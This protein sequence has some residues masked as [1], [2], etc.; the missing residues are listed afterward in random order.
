MTFFLSLTSWNLMVPTSGAFIG[1]ENYGRMIS[2]RYFGNAILITLILI[3]GPVAFQMLLGLALALLLHT[4]LPFLPVSRAVFI[5]PMV[6]P[7]VIAGLIWKVL[8]IPNLG[9]VNYFLGLVG[10]SGPNWLDTPIWA[11]IA[12]GLVAIWEDTPFVMLLLLAALDSLPPEPFEAAIVDGASVWQRIRFV[13]IPLITPA[14]LVAVLFRIIASLNIF[15]VIYVM[16]KGGPGRFTEVLNYYAY[17]HGFQFLDIG[18]A[19]ALAM[20]LFVLIV[21]LSGLF[22]VLRVR[23]AGAE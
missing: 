6:I 22:M 3:F 16:T 17:T 11:L 9:G 4:D 15:P 5:T 14:I 2:D 1:L 21:V 7:P 18:Y 12:V 13:T 20:G 23:L 10:I 19:S 8:F